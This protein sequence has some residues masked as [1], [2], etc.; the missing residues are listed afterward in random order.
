[1]KML[2]KELSGY[3]INEIIDSLLKYMDR[4]KNGVLVPLSGGVDSSVLA[5]LA[6][7]KFKD[8]SR[9]VTFDS[10]LTPRYLLEAS[11]KVAKYI[12]IKHIIVKSNEFAIKEFTRNPINRCYICKKYRFKVLKEILLREKLDAILDGTTFSDL[13]VYRPGLKAIE[14]IKEY[15]KTPYIDLKIS[16]DITRKLASYFKIPTYNYPPD[17][18]LA[19]RVMYNEELTPE[20][21][22]KIDIA[23][24]YIRNLIGL[25]PIRVRLHGDLVRIEVPLDSFTDILKHKDLIRLKF[26]ELGFNYITLDLEGFRSGSFDIYVK[27]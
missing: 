23:E 4:F 1:M 10:Q 21:L 15:V 27:K 9:A 17:S 13:S 25:K 8:K 18:C 12:G 20:K 6:Y 2:G 3:D 14:E 24:D 7:K 11:K 16:K 19:T 22:Q 5:L 26:H